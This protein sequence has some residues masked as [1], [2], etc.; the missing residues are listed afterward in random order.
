MNV[1][2]PIDLLLLDWRAEFI[3]FDKMLE[4]REIDLSGPPI[5]FT[6]HWKKNTLAIWFS[7]L[8]FYAST[9]NTPVYTWNNMAKTLVNC[10]DTQSKQMS[11]L[12]PDSERISNNTLYVCIPHAWWF[13]ERCNDSWCAHSLSLSLR[14]WCIAKCVCLISEC[15][16]WVTKN[17]NRADEKRMT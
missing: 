10:F 9:S 11:T 12:V 1:L 8:V 3:R 5:A 14:M 13:N 15:F 16:A 4:K 6:E 17:R 7:P 2:L